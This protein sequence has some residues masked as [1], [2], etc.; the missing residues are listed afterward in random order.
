VAVFWT[1]WVQKDEIY[2]THRAGGHELKVSVHSTGQV[3]MYMGLRNKQLFAP[4]LVLGNG[5][6]RGALEIRFLLGA[7]ADVPPERMLKMKKK[8]DKALLVEVLDG[9]TLCL[10]L[11]VSAQAGPAPALPNECPGAAQIWR[12]RLR[13]GRYVVLL[14]RIIP[15]DEQS[16]SVLRHIRIERQ[17]KLNFV[18]SP[19]REAPYGEALHAYWSD[20]GNVIFVVPL[21]A[22]GRRFDPENAGAKSGGPVDSRA[23]TVDCPDA[24]TNLI[25][26]DGAVVGLISIKGSSGQLLLVKDNEVM[27]PIG[28]VSLQI[29]SAALR[30]G[31]ENEFT[32]PRF[33][34]ECTLVIGGARMRRW[35]YLYEL[36]FDGSALSVSILPLSVALRNANLNNAIPGLGSAEEI[37]VRAPAATVLRLTAREDQARA[38]TDLTGGFRLRDI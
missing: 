9:Q 11:L 34:M 10:D 27:H 20:H 24:S 8:K 23:L 21:G 36:S 3:H 12:T 14:S 35:E 30:W 25:A 16:T 6:W 7:G 33:S 32:R 22:E 17:L 28:E 29:Y 18:G 13:D 5:S 38:S 15:F 26:P 4:P 1:F 2:I 37:V 19:P 31:K